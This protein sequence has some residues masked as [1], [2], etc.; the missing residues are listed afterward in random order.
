MPR[1][2]LVVGQ[3]PRGVGR[4]LAMSEGP[5]TPG[6]R[7]TQLAAARPD[8]IAV[9]SERWLWGDE[10]L[11]RLELEQWVNRLAHRFAYLSV[12]PGSFVA[13]NLPNCLEHVVATLATFKLGGCPMPLSYRMPPFERDAMMAL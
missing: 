7:L 5:V 12:G 9:I 10:A 3:G 2:Q 4:A 8:E 11:T 6:A 1:T 13:I